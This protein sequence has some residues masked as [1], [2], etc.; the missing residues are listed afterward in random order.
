[1]AEDSRIEVPVLVT[2][3]PTSIAERQNECYS[4]QMQKAKH[5]FF[6]EAKRWHYI[7]IFGSVSLAVAGLSISAFWPDAQTTVG[8]IGSAWAVI[9]QLILQQ[10][11]LCAT[12][13]SCKRPRA[14]RLFRFPTAL[15]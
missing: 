2:A 4:I 9:V 11:E 13:K 3:E 15:E 10:L 12:K 1:V 8:A 14:V 6:A 5:V 7:R